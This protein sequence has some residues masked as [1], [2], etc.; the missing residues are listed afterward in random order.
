MSS[1][2][3]LSCSRSGCR[4][5]MAPITKAAPM[6]CK[7]PKASPKKKKHM[8]PAEMGSRVAVI[9]ARVERYMIDPHKVETEGKDRF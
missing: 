4:K 2:V 6:I 7:G 1:G 8:K 3:I 9:M 5:T